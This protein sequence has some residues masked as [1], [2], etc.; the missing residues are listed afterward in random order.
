MMISPESYYEMNLKGKSDK[1]IISAIRGLKNEIGHLK[2]VMEH[3]DYGSEPIIHPSESTRLW[4]TREYLER[5]KEALA[6]A[7]GVYKP[8]QAEIKAQEFDEN[9]PFIK[10]IVFSIGGYFGG[11]ETRTITFDDEMKVC[12]THSLE[13]DEEPIEPVLFP[14][15]K[16]EFLDEL[17]RLHIGEW[18]KTYSPERYGYA[19]LDGTQW[20]LEIHF[21][22]DTKPF[23]CYGSNSYP[24]NFNEFQELLG[25]DTSEYEDEEDEDE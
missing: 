25:I 1:Q 18:R 4:C 12:I 14:I 19:V 11:Y 20:E 7:G 6:E 22:N 9:L 2:N 23:K 3:P 13:F 5:A 17:S 15:Q 21:A 16:D 10:K 24:Y 8:S